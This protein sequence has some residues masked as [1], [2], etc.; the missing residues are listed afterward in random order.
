ML[1]IY[2]SANFSNESSRL[3]NVY[4]RNAVL[5]KIVKIPL[6]PII[7]L[8]SLVGSALIIIIVRKGV[9]LRNT[10]SYFFVNMAV[11]DF[12]FP[13][14]SIPVHL[15]FDTDSE[16]FWRMACWW[17]NGTDILQATVVPA[18]IS[19]AVSKQSLVWIAFDQFVAV[20]LPINV[21]SVV[22]IY[23]PLEFYR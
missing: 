22:G 11:S 1:S 21:I 19:G 14:I 6:F 13:L 10:I 18:S 2:M 23:L 3:Q 7:L 9:E 8:S 15:I 5:A 12:V 16:Q 20:V 17:N 4:L